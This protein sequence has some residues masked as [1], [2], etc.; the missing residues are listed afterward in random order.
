MAHLKLIILKKTLQF[1]TPCKA[2]CGYV[3]QLKQQI[4]KRCYYLAAH[5]RVLNVLKSDES[6]EPMEEVSLKGLGED[7][8]I[9][10]QTRGNESTESK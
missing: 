1:K 10:Y 8:V 2:D 4:S 7:W 9:V 3:T 5:R 6:M